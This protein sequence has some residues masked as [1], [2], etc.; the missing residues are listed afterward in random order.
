MTVR[1]KSVDYFDDAL[2]S[3]TAAVQI[4]LAQRPPYYQ[5]AESEK[6]SVF[7]TIVQPAW[8][9][10][11]TEMTIQLRSSSEGTQV[12]VKTES[13]WFILGDILNFYDHYIYDFLTELR[14]ELWCQ[15]SG[16]TRAVS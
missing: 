13:Q 2:P 16:Q 11:G 5:V 9:L 12:V 15:R 8:W 4:V 10:L 6:D 3:V 1:R 14:S 7:K